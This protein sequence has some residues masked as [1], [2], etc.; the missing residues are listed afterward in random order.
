MTEK[1]QMS[2]RDSLLWGVFCSLIGGVVATAL[3]YI[4]FLRKEKII[5]SYFIAG[6]CFMFLMTLAI[7]GAITVAGLLQIY[8]ME[9]Y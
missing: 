8:V 2:M 5:L 6:Y 4:L 1:K 3:F 9:M 7:T